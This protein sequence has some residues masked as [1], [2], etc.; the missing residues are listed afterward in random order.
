[1]FSIFSKYADEIMRYSQYMD[2]FVL[3]LIYISSAS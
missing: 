1:M 3:K 2:E